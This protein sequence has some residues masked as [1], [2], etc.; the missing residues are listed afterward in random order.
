MQCRNFED[1][2]SRYFSDVDA[3]VYR[4]AM[5]KEKWF[6]LK[7]TTDTKQRALIEHLS[8]CSDCSNC[9]WQYLSIRDKVDYHEYPCF[10]LAYYCVDE[11]ERC[12]SQH[13]GLFSIIL[14]RAEGTGIVI[15]ACPWCNS[16]A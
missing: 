16:K 7:S 10:H 15:G 6:S 9:L 13:H 8:R 1:S 2:M 5:T 4:E 14:D 11:E 3:D 12:I